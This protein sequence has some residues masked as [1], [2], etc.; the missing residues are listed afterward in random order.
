MQLWVLR[1]S[2]MALTTFWTGRAY[3]DGFEVDYR[4]SE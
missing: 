2:V 4:T 3:A 1:L